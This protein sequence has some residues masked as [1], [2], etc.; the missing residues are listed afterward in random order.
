MPRN[1]II[2]AIA[3]FRSAGRPSPLESRRGCRHG[4]IYKRV[5]LNS[6]SSSSYSSSFLAW[7]TKHLSLSFA[8]SHFFL[9]L[10]IPDLI[11]ILIDTSYHCYY[12]FGNCSHTFSSVFLF[13]EVTTKNERENSIVPVS[14]GKKRVP[15]QRKVPG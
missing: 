5:R 10:F 12:Y 8:S 7:E 2:N 9:R 4:G 3:C 15:K 14:R 11:L 6:A 1:M 13:L